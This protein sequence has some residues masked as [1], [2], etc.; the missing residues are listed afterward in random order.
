MLSPNSVGRK[1]KVKLC[2]SKNPLPVSNAFLMYELEETSRKG[3]AM[4]N[5]KTHMKIRY[6]VPMNIPSDCEEIKYR[7]GA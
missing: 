3:S 4:K 2:W 7:A 1:L 5:W 6:K